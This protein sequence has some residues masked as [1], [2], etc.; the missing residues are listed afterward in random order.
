[1]GVV[2]YGPSGGV[3][4]SGS[5]PAQ[6]VEEIKLAPVLLT[7]PEAGVRAVPD[8]DVQLVLSPRVGLEQGRTLITRGSR[9]VRLILSV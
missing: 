7:H 3:V 5:D 9:Q 8:G 2:A 4:V 1:V 6:M